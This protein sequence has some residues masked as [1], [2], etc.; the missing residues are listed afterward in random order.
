MAGLGMK[1]VLVTGASG[2]V[3]RACLPLL[4][5]Q[6]FEVHAVSQQHQ[7]NNSPIQ[8]HRGDI[9]KSNV[10][11]ELM[12]RHCPTHL[13]HLAWCTEPSTF[14]SSPENHEWRDRS[15]DLFHLFEQ[16]GGQRIVGTGS[17][18]EYD[19][20]NGVCHEQHSSTVPNTLYGQTKLATATALLSM[21][22]EKLSVAWARLFFLY[23][24]S[25]S[26]R[27]MPGLV[28]SALCRNEVACCSDGTQQRDFL[29]ISDAA[30]ALVRLLDSELTGAVNVCSGEAVSIRDIAIGAANLMQKRELL[31]LGVLPRSPHEPPLIVGDCTRLRQELNWVRQF[32]LA[33][34]L[35]DTITHWPE[36]LARHCA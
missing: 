11:R 14:W 12:K 5:A 27:R 18:A 31:Q 10:L 4:V 28:I 26:A 36:S 24:P 22:D 33:E 15:L 21:N 13:L 32:T 30:D 9:K 20:T 2:F 19:W 23:G 16:S 35:R 7:P 29:H 1:R 6:G 8:W 17:C 25:A 3:G 34:G